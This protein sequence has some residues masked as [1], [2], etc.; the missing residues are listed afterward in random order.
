[1]YN[2]EHVSFG[3][4]DWL[5]LQW[6][7]SW[8]CSSVSFVAEQLVSRVKHNEVLHIN[9]AD[10]NM[11]TSAAASRSA[12]VWPH[13]PR[14]LCHSTF[15]LNRNYK[16]THICTPQAHIFTLVHS[17]VRLSRLVLF[18]SAFDNVSCT[19]YDEH[20]Y[21]GSGFPSETRA[22]WRFYKSLYQCM[23]LCFISQMLQE[24]T[25]TRHILWLFSDNLPGVFEI[26]YTEKK[27][28]R[29]LNFPIVY[30]TL[31]RTFLRSKLFLFAK[32][33]LLLKIQLPE[34]FYF[35]TNAMWI[36]RTMYLL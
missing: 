15:A 18:I 14:C 6:N 8:H 32:W 26:R 24:T 36:H 21:Q 16:V 25:L 5:F 10:P 13:R 1:M 12:R 3:R 20:S 11:T 35:M 29:S 28:P 31:L 17:V 33:N 22:F 7:S 23:T 27:L 4:Q 34:K 30:I 9:E 2:N 19:D